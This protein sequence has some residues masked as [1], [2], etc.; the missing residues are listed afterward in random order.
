MS[1]QN[2]RVLLQYI[3]GFVLSHFAMVE[4][5]FAQQNSAPV[6]TPVL[7]TELI[8]TTSIEGALAKLQPPVIKTQIEKS[9]YLLLDLPDIAIAGTINVRMMSEIPGTDLF[10]LFDN[11]PRPNQSALLAV[12]AI[13]PGTGADVKTQINIG[14]SSELILLARAN[15]R[16]YSVTRQIKLAQKD[17]AK[18]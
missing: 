15:G 17:H 4:L 8:K 9:D 1:R 5:A 6:P 7:V 13:P 3:V 16:V 14:Y 12:Q 2:K 18:P 11:N 10:M